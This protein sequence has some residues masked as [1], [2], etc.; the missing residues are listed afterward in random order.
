MN[1]QLWRKDLVKTARGRFL[2]LV[3]SWLYGAAVAARRLLFFLRVI[4]SRRLQA[5]TVC[6]GNL[7]TGGT[8]KTPAVL[9]AAH[10][11]HKADLKC[12]I[13]SRGYKRRNPTREVQVLL[14]TQNVSWHETGDEPWMMHL[15]LQGMDIPILIS[16]NRY[17]AGEEAMTYYNSKV[18]LLDDGLQHHRLKRD[19]DIIL[20][21]A[22]DP[23][24]GGALLPLGNLR[25]PLSALK[26]AGL[27]V[28]THADEVTPERIEEITAVVQKYN[29][30]A[31]ILEAAHRPD[32]LLD[33]KT[34]VQ[35][36]LNHLKGAKVACISAIGHPPSFES[37][38][39]E[40]GIE[41]AQAWR[42]PDHHAFTLDELRSVENV[43]GEMPIVTT[44]KDAPR[45]PHG[46]Q[47]LWKGPVY[48]LGIKMEITKGQKTWETELTKRRH[49]N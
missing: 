34:N 23:W 29:G 6:I 49:R 25:E 19:L 32:F 48:A 44:L 45:L 7:T 28:L 47:A 39:R 26:R 31:P 13:L 10:T 8:G 40:V 9:L 35:H 14:N 18:L 42:Y 46:W 2:L 3:L 22:L 37:K 5:K 15:A 4:P 38:L 27:I 24:G 1:L 36:K 11:L 43:R 30:D 20:I 33:L 41:L 12:A 17:R 16:P 21:N